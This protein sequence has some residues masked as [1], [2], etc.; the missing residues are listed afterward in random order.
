MQYLFIH[1]FIFFLLVL[2][3]FVVGFRLADS[4]FRT[5]FEDAAVSSLEENFMA[6]SSEERLN[7]HTHT[8]TD[9][10]NTIIIYKCRF[11]M[12]HK[13]IIPNGSNKSTPYV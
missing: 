7:T 4:C 13:H 12:H 1:M 10:K 6:L 9:K 3:L 5:V 8:N 11:I 2:F